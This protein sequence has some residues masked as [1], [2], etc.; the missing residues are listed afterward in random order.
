[1]ARYGCYDMRPEATVII[2]CCGIICDVKVYFWPIR[3]LNDPP[4][5]Y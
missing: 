4:E 2:A 5:D 3:W 1:M